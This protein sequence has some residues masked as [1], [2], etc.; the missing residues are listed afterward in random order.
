MFSFLPIWYGHYPKFDFEIHSNAFCGFVRTKCIMAVPRAARD[1]LGG[2]RARVKEGR[3]EK[4]KRRDRG[5]EGAYDEGDE[6]RW[7]D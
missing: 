4:L 2:L 3:E 6:E 5:K 1:I 7:S